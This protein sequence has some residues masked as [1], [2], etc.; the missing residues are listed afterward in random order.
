MQLGH[1]FWIAFAQGV[2]A[3]GGDPRIVTTKV[4]ALA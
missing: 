2:R 3:R 1:E 4:A